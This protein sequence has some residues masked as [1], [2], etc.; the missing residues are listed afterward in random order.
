[1]NKFLPVWK[2]IVFAN[3]FLFLAMPCKVGLNVEIGE[4]GNEWQEVNH[5]DP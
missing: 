2:E 3:L 1:M 4:E 5:V